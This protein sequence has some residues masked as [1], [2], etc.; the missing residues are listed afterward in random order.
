[1]PERVF[2]YSI[3]F[4]VCLWKIADF[5]SPSLSLLEFSSRLFLFCSCS[6]WL[7]SSLPP[8]LL[9]SR[10]LLF[11]P[12]LPVHQLK[13]FICIKMMTLRAKTTYTF[14]RHIMHRLKVLF[15]GCRKTRFTLQPQTFHPGISGNIQEPNSNHNIYVSS[16]FFSP[17]S[18]SHLVRNAK[19]FIRERE[20]ERK[21]PASFE[22]RR[23]NMYPDSFTVLF[24]VQ[25][26]K[27]IKLGACSFSLER[28]KKH[29]KYNVLLH[30]MLFWKRP[31]KTN[32]MLEK[33]KRK[34]CLLPIYCR[35]CV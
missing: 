2:F 6:Q 21:N 20:R 16:L 30:T 13:W 11:S 14:H 7:L 34:K 18:L 9:F 24:F 35:E 22:G 8:P 4:T 31:K 27:K 12:P 32:K 1:M 5:G 15:F 3:Q 28:I 25:Q 10:C 17:I 33:T 23:K 29:I 19:A 26:S